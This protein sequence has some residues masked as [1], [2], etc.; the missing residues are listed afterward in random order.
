M[1]LR[2]ELALLDA[3][4]NTL[5]GFANYIDSE[6][7]TEL[8]CDIDK[9][10]ERYKQILEDVTERRANIKTLVLISPDALDQEM[11]PDSA[12]EEDED[13]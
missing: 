3:K 4:K 11:D 2:E 1:T 7:L 10:K 13:D 5:K 8:V 6:F 9:T 12:Y